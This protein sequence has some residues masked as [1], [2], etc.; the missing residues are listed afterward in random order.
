MKQLLLIAILLLTFCLVACEK[1]I[2]SEPEVTTTAST[3]ESVTATVKATK[4]TTVAATVTTTPSVTTTVLLTTTAPP[5]VTKKT[6]TATP[7]KEPPKVTVTSAETAVTTTETELSWGLYD[8]SKLEFFTDKATYKNNEKGTVILNNLSYDVVCF[9]PGAKLFYF[10]G[11]T[12]VKK[13][14]SGNYGEVIIELGYQN[15]DSLSGDFFRFDL[16]KDYPEKLSA[17]KYRFEK[18]VSWVYTIAGD[19]VEPVTLTAEFEIVE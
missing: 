9:G 7:K 17:G 10:D 14:W 2:N 4:T 19:I 15:D 13:G 11:T 16:A 1:P 8:S 18:T 3:A 6:G 5:A 12:W